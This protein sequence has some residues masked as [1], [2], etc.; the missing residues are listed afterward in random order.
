M[1][2]ACVKPWDIRKASVKDK[3][4]SCRSSPMGPYPDGSKQMCIEECH[5][6]G[7]GREK[8]IKAAASFLQKSF[9]KKKF[10]SNLSK[11]LAEARLRIAEKKKKTSSG[12]TKKSG[13]RK[14]TGCPAKPRSACS[15]PCKW[16][17]G[18]KRS[19][20][21]KEKNKKR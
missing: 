16:A 9:K 1:P 10:T 7:P 2:S 18:T 8:T 3:L 20:C 17:S 21:R 5:T 11:R 6:D 4:K 14:K 15:S 13:T 19:F 12:K